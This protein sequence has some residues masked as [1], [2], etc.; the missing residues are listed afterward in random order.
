[1]DTLSHRRFWSRSEPGPH[2]HS[3]LSLQ[4]PSHLDQPSAPAVNRQVFQLDPEDLSQ[5]AIATLA[6]LWPK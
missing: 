5:P 6:Q 1:M 2:P 3:R 4:Q